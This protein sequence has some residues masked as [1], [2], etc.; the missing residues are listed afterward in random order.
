MT[1]QELADKVHE[2]RQLRLK[3]LMN[4]MNAHEQKRLDKLEQALAKREA[5]QARKSLGAHLRR[6]DA[7]QHMREYLISIGRE[8]LLE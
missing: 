7:A 3:A 4:F 1:P 8:D 6:K 5:L 2:L